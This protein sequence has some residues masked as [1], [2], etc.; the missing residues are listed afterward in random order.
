[1]KWSGA[2]PGYA[3]NP[4]TGEFFTVGAALFSPAGKPFIAR[5]INLQYGDNPSEKMPSFGPIAWTNANIVR[6]QL[7]DNTTN[8]ELEQ[9]LDAI[10]NRGMVAM[11]ML[12]EHYLTCHHNT[13]QLTNAVQNLWVNRWKTVLQKQKYKGKLLINIANEWGE[14]YNNYQDF[15]SAYESVIST[16]R[17]A[18]FK[19]PLV[20]DGA[21]CG[22]YKNTFLSNRGR[23]LINHDPEN[24]LVF[25]LHAYHWLWNTKGEINQAFLDYRGANIPLMMGE[26]GDSEFQAPNNVNHMY[27]MERAQALDVGWIAWSWK[28]NGTAEELV[29]DMSET[30][31][32]ANLTRHGTD[33]VWGPNGLKYTA[34]SAF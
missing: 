2:D 34:K 14:N 21:H 29:L 11:P 18:G 6:L 31:S 10:V 24:N 28:G 23:D 20:I 19:Q 27:L 8:W 30:Y 33:I 4:N 12:W 5:G 32:P 3:T 9:A 7:R 17:G 16:L 22:Q 26:F 25:S 1:M 15:I 13:W